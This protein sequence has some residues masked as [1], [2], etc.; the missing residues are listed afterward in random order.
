MS[1][2]FKEALQDVFEERAGEFGAGALELLE[3]LFERGVLE[4]RQRER[5]ES[6]QQF[7]LE[8]AVRSECG[9]YL[10]VPV[11]RHMLV[12]EGA[13]AGAERLEH[14]IRTRQRELGRSA[15]G[16]AFSEA[17]K[18]M[19]QVILEKLAS[20]ARA[21]EARHSS[22][23]VL[24]TPPAAPRAPARQRANEMRWT[25]ASALVRDIQAQERHW[26]QEMFGRFATELPPSKKGLP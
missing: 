9:N 24:V 12:L 23:L 25:D 26:V 14:E 1:S 8:D 11:P 19:D 22:T 3:Q 15:D 5:V 18:A 13:E 20:H 17:L 4:G 10:C 6:A 2:E 21:L 7:P 16:T